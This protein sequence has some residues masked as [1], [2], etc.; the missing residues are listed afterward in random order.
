MSAKFNFITLKQLEQEKDSTAL[1]V[2]NRTNPRGDL[3]IT[4]P[5]G[6]GG[7][8]IIVIP[9]TWIPM[10]LTTQATRDSLVKSPIVRRLVTKGAIG[11]IDEDQAELIM[12]AEDAKEEADRVYSVERSIASDPLLKSPE[13]EK[14]EDE[15]SGKISGFAMNIVGIELEEDKVL[16]MI[17]NQGDVLTKED[18]EYIATNSVMGK[19]KEYCAAEALQA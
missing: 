6:L 19:V 4:M 12:E 15:Q 16:S 7:N 1:W 5:D 13:I 8:T 14:I 9:V 3:N 17:R 18:F 2:V 10:D 11:I